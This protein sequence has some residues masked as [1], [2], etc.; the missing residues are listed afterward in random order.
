MLS[1]LGAE[2]NPDNLPT[3]A[4]FHIELASVPHSYMLRGLSPSN[5]Q[6]PS[7]RRTAIALLNNQRHGFLLKFRTEYSAFLFHLTPRFES[8]S[9]YDP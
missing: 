6:T 9:L 7:R 3:S 4:S 2:V 1:E 5:A 8:L